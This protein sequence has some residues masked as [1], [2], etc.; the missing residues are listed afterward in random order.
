MTYHTLT[1]FAADAIS[2]LTQPLEKASYGN[3]L[4]GFKSSLYD[5]PIE[6]S[7]L[8]VHKTSQEMLNAV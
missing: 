8:I 3:S 2:R 5:W 6:A 1:C 4:A 7:G